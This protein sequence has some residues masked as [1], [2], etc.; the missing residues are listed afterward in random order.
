MQIV[1][2][3]TSATGS[4]GK[5]RSMRHTMLMLASV[6][7]VR[8]HPAGIKVSVV[9]TALLL[10][11]LATAR[12]GQ[13]LPQHRGLV[14]LDPRAQHSDIFYRSLVA[15]CSQWEVPYCCSSLPAEHP[16]STG[17]YFC[18]L[19]AQVLCNAASHL[20]VLSVVQALVVPLSVIA[21]CSSAF[22]ACAAL[23]PAKEL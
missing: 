11:T 17:R 1:P 8:R 21:F 19:A 4:R 7:T 23:L 12:S 13:P 10:L 18:L 6:L 2:A 22:A 20:Q 5:D 16:R 14:V 9:F 15:A 3:V